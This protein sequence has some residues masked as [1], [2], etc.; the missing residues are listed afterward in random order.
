MLDTIPF[1]NKRREAFSNPRIL[2]TNRGGVMDRIKP[3][4]FTSF[5][6]EKIKAAVLFQ[7]VVGQGLEYAKRSKEMDTPIVVVEHGRGAISD[8]LA[9]RKMPL[10]ADKVCVWGSFD[11]YVL[12]NGG[13]DEEKIV[14]TGC[15]IFEGLSRTKTSHKGM[16]VLFSPAHFTE[17]KDDE[18]LNVQILNKLNSIKD[19]TVYT[20]LLNTHSKELRTKHS[21]ISTSY[22]DDHLNKCIEA[23]KLADAIVSNQIGTFELIA[24]YFEIPVIYVNNRPAETNVLLNYYEKSDPKDLGLVFINDI[25]ELEKSINKCFADPHALRK[26]CQEVLLTQ[27]GVGLTG[28]ATQKIIETIKDI[29]L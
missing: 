7:D 26:E 5:N 10:L 22:D 20:K 12:I 27:A 4:F 2:L 11:R 18:P 23:I 25:E 3:Y 17:N 1:I 14:L 19:I 9:P 21:V 29:A 13:I 16:N 24:M 15:P 6:F 28:S 8:Y